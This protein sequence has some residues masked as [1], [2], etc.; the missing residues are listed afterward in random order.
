MLDDC[1]AS[2]MKELI[3]QHFGSVVLA[4]AILLA[5]IIHGCTIRYVAL[6]GAFGTDVV[7]RWTGERK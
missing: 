7:D 4:V 1:H 6:K 2:R 3:K 5:V